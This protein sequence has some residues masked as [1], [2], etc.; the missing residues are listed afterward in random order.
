MRVFQLGLMRM[1]FTWIVLGLLAA[2]AVLWAALKWDDYRKLQRQQMQDLVMG[3]KRRDADP[4]PVNPRIDTAS[5]QLRATPAAKPLIGSRLRLKYIDAKGKLTERD[6][7]PDMNR[8]QQD[9]FDAWCTL[10]HEERT[11]F[12]SRVQSAVDLST[13]ECLNAMQLSI[14]IRLQAFT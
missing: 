7:I 11:F 2:A 14:A 8:V 9:R 3:R 6:V 4:A 5:A 12:F 1:G 13:G 10:R